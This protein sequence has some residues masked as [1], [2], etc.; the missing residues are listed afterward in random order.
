MFGVL[1]IDECGASSPVCDINAN[2]SN[3]RGS[4]ICTCRTGY[5]GDGKTCQDID[6]CS[7]SSPVCDS[8]ANC[9]N[10]RGSYICTCKAGYYGD[11][12]TCGV[13][14]EGLNDSVI[15][16]D[17]V[18][19]LANLSAWLKPVAQ[20]ESSKW[21]RCWRASVDGWAAS[22]FHSGC[23]N[24]GPTV[25]IIRVGGKYICGGYTNLSWGKL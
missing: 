7:A 20:S 13:F 11:G 23:D 19:H 15:L 5:T 2:C 9:S 21:K 8:N 10:T 25:T 24:K 22:T 12:K 18:H 3:T 14:A 6:E 16:R 1:D 4:Y 17:N